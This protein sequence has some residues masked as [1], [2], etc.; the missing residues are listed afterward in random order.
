M[1]AGEWKI[2]QSF[3]QSTWKTEY[4]KLNNIWIIYTDDINQNNL[5]VLRTF[6]NLKKTFLWNSTPRRQF[7][8]KISNRKKISNEHFNLCEAETFLDEIIKSIKSQKNN[9]SPGN[10]GLKAISYK[11]FSNEL[12]PVLLYVY[13]SWGNLGTIGVTSRTGILSV[14]YEKGDKRGI[15][16]YRPTSFLNLDCKFI[17][18]FFRIECEK[19]IRYNNRWKPVL[20][21]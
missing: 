13:D 8:S 6:S 12:A 5:T 16:N 1:G 2:L 17:L 10:D 15:E 11:D 4:A 14:M 9:K 7:L 21:Y 3:F 20:F 19:I 18:E